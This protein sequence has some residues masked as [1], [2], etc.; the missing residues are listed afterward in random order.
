VVVTGVVDV[1]FDSE[2]P[3]SATMIVA[4]T[5]GVPH[6]VLRMLATAVRSTMARSRW[7]LKVFTFRRPA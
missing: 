5:T 6:Q 3:T 7:W 1:V 4:T 2:Q